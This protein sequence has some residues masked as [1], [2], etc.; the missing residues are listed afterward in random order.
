M[1]EYHK[2]QTVFK[3]NP[4][5][6]FKTLLDEYSLPE[7]EYLKDNE[8]TWTE[9]IDGTN[10]RVMWDG[11]DVAFAGKTDKAIIPNHLLDVLDDIFKAPEMY[12]KFGVDGDVCLYGEGYGMKIQKG[13]NYIPD[14]ADFILFDCKIGPWWMDRASLEDISKSLCV[15]IVPIIEKGTLTE[16]VDYCKSGYKSTISDNKDYDA[17]G[18]V[19]KPSVELIA[20]NGQ[21]II[22]KIKSK[23]FR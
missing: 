20:R 5:T 19:L 2:I 8:W 15:G 3:R 6:N 1:I 10:I 9:K 21:R 13:G 4:E 14:R 12:K 22:S 23:D 16:A 18:L 7:F 11:A 17:E